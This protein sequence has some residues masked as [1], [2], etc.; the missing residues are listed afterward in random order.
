VNLF[1]ATESL[2]QRVTVVPS[3]NTPTRVSPFFTLLP[4]KNSLIENVW[5]ML[6]DF[7]NKGFR[8]KYKVNLVAR[9]HL[10]WKEFST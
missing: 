6:E 2:S 9:I 4:K 3:R 7:V 1:L 5:K 10:V 8:P